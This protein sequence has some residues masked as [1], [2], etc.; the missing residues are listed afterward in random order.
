M[1]KKDLR[2]S[3]PRNFRLIRKLV[4]AVPAVSL[5]IYLSHHVRVFTFLP[6]DSRSVEE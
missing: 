3:P 2:R 6:R 4:P 5:V 1:R